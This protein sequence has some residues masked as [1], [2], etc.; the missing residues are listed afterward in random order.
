MAKK[1]EMKSIEWH[2]DCLQNATKHYR[3]ML[4]DALAMREKAEQGLKDCE[5]KARE[6][7]IAQFKGITELP[8]NE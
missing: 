2:L 5:N 6:I 8:T 1:K 7:A 3:R 4:G